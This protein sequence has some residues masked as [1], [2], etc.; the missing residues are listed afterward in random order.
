VTTSFNDT[1][2]KFSTGVNDTGGKI[3]AGINNTGRKL[4][5]GINNTGG[6]ICHQFFLVL[7]IPVAA[8]SVNDTGSKFA[9]SV[10]D[11]CGHKPLT[12]MT[13]VFLYAPAPP[14]PT[15]MGPEASLVSSCT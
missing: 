13:P 12:S 10:N 2:D 15:V 9:V 6:K 14:P 11:T 3:D 4:A 8:T 5:T 1:G 7:L